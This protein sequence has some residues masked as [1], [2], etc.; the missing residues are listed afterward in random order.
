MLEQ[1]HDSVISTTLDGTILTWNIGAEKFYE[2]KQN[3][4]IGK[5]VSMLYLNEDLPLLGYIAVFR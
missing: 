1:I 3:E 5:N 4:A 2:Y